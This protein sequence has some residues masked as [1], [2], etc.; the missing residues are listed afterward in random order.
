MNINK[1]LLLKQHP[2]IL[3]TFAIHADRKIDANKPDITINDHKNNF[4]LL[5]ELMFSMDKN[6][7]S[8]EFGKI[9]KYKNMEIKIERIWYLKPT[10]I[11]VIL[12]VFGTVKK[13]QVNIYNKSWKAKSNRKPESCTSK[14]SKY[15]EKNIVNLNQ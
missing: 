11:P 9:S 2:T 10:L 5:V 8:G 4:C 7:L 1:N 15:S 6:L 3:W 13:V 12:G 14:P